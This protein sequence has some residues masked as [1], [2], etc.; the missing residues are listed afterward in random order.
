MTNERKI[1]KV[2]ETTVTEI[3][4]GRYKGTYGPGFA[5]GVT[6]PGHCGHNYKIGACPYCWP[7]A[8][9]IE[10]AARRG[11]DHDTIER[12]PAYGV[13]RLGRGTGHNVLVGSDFIHQ[14]C[15]TI[16]ISVAE[17]HRG[18]HEDRW[19]ARKTLI[20][21]DLSEAQWAT[22]VSSV[23]NGSGVPCTIR[24][25]EAGPVSRLPDPKPR[26]EQF[27]AELDQK[28]GQIRE[29]VAMLQKMV[30]E[31]AGK[32]ALRDGLHQVSMAIGGNLDF[33]ATQFTEHM[34][35]TV[36]SA[37]A[38]IHAHLNAAVRTAGLE[39]IGAVA[40]LALGSGEDAS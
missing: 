16:E 17:L 39:A 36:E 2:G 21:V 6:Q 20:E 11:G 37:K 27:S 1:S 23:G 22:Y 5:V 40:P 4:E 3:T 14:H 18:L 10:A 30:E 33:V 15:V 29:R 31:G 26:T 35:K 12:H 13:I 28:L 8:P 7:Q 34:E 38:E 9:M 19:H 24:R 25:V 32:K